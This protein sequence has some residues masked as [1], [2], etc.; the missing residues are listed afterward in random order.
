MGEFG[1]SNGAK[2][3]LE[4]D[5]RRVENRSCRTHPGAEQGTVRGSL[6][7]GMVPGMFDRLSLSQSAYGEE[8]E[9]QEDRQEF[10]GAVVHRKAVQCYSFKF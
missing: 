6:M 3:G 2:L 5:H 10:K 8:T 4:R 9:H 7:L 1:E